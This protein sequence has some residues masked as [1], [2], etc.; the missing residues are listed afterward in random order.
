MPLLA[1]QTIVKSKSKIE[2]DD[3]LHKERRTFTQ[4]TSSFVCPNAPPRTFIKIHLKETDDMLLYEH[5]SFAVLADSIEAKQ[6]QEEICKPKRKLRKTID[7]ESQ[8]LGTLLKSRAVNTIHIKKKN[9]KAFVSNYDMFDTYNN[10][11]RQTESLDIEID[12]EP[13]KFEITTYFKRNLDDL[14]GK[15][16]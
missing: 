5:N 7:V 13:G 8:T 3:V 16:E 6:I 15:L 10:L 9:V 11:A 1:Q 14:S 12:N 4:S 2:E